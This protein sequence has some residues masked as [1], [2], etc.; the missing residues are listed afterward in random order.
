MMTPYTAFFSQPI[1]CEKRDR[2]FPSDEFGV[3]SLE[4]YLGEFSGTADGI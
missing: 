4:E 3:G 1:L 2:R